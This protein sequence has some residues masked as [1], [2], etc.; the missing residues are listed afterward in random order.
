M[1]T[2]VTNK[3]NKTNKTTLGGTLKSFPSTCYRR[4]YPNSCNKKAT[5]IILDTTN[6]N[7]TT[8]TT[9]I[10]LSILQPHSHRSISFSAPK[11]PCFSLLRAAQ[12][13][14]L[15]DTTPPTAHKDQSYSY[16]PHLP[17][18]IQKAIRYILK[19]VFIEACSPWSLVNPNLSSTVSPRYITRKC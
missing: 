15:L 6:S 7:T 13:S 9:A 18:V 16:L 8:P 3:T 2:F 17:Q 11:I 19:W 10:N 4:Q 12:P 14:I 1:L 5:G